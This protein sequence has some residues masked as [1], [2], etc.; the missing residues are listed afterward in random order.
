MFSQFVEFNKPQKTIHKSQK[1]ILTINVEEL[2]FFLGPRRLLKT[3]IFEKKG[4]FLVN[5]CICPTF[6]QT[7]EYDK[8]QETMY[9]GQKDILTFT[10]QVMR[11]F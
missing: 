4:S 1:D 3:Q 11:V 6:S 2:R 5:K 9:K 8:P 10:V 7:V